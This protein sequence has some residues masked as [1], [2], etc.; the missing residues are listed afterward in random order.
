MTA[1]DPNLDIA[2]INAYMKFGEILSINSQDIE[3]KRNS[4]ANQGLSLWNKCEK[5]MYNNPKVDLVNINAYR[6]FGVAL[7]ILS[8]Y[9]ILV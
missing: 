1:N 4:G 7:Q 3:R 5:L 8:V 2:R 6:K 9:E